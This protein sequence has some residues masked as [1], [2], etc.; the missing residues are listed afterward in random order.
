MTLHR[1]SPLADVDVD[2]DKREFDVTICGLEWSICRLFGLAEETDKV[3]VAVFE[4]DRAVEVKGL[5]VRRADGLENSAEID[6]AE[7]LEFRIDDEP[8]PGLRR[9]RMHKPARLLRS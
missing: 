9:A 1:P 3:T 5:T 8:I 2:L 7:N 4:A 6:L